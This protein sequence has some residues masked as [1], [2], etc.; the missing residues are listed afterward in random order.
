MRTLWLPLALLLVAVPV[1]I[2]AD[3]APTATAVVCTTVKDRAP[4]GA[5]EKF[6][7]SVGQLTCFSE[8]HGVKEKVVHVWFHGDK[9]VARME[10]P[11]KAERWR[12]WSTKNIPAAWTGPWRVEVR[13][14]SGGVLATAKFTVE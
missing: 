6:A 8:L 12:T 13:D 7:A 2:A 4:E 10:L 3:V 14:G 5:A 11:V 9:E 1:V